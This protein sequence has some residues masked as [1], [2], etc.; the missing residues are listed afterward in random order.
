MALAQAAKQDGHRRFARQ[1]GGLLPVFADP[2][3][4]D[5][6]NEVIG[7]GARE[8]DHVAGLVGLGALNQRNEVADQFDPEKIHRRC[9]DVHQH[10]GPVLTDSERLKVCCHGIESVMESSNCTTPIGR[11]ADSLDSRS[12]RSSVW[13]RARIY[14]FETWMCRLPKRRASI[15]QAPRPIMANVAPRTASMAE[16]TG[17]PALDHSNHASAIAISVPATGIHKPIRRSIP[18]TAPTACATITAHGASSY[19]PI[20]P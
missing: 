16:G 18:A 7:V 19:E 20:I 8:D 1:P 17:L 11:C 6:R 5:V 4:I 14:S 10:H 3:H 15:D 9:R 12:R 13:G 2:R